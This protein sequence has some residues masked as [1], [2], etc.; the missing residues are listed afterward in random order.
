MSGQGNVVERV[1]K[2]LFKINHI[3]FSNIG[4]YY[5]GAEMLMKGGKELR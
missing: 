5:I 3:M 4:S 2:G 1:N